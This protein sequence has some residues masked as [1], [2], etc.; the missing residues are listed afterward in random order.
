MQARR[1]R[2]VESVSAAQWDACFP[3]DYPFTRHAFLSALERSGSVGGD[4]GWGPSHLAIEQDDVVVGAAPVY[5]KAHSYGEFV[6]D[7]AWAQVCRKLRIRY[8]PKA[9]LAVPFTP[10]AG[11]RLG[12]KS[13]AA[14]T[15]LVAA[16]QTLTEAQGLSSAHALFLTGEEAEV[17]AAAGFMA[18][19]DIQFHWHNPGYADFAGFLAQLSHDKRK[20]ILRERRRIQEAGLRFERECGEA[21][22]ESAWMEVYALYANTYHERGQAP[23]L[24]PEFF[25]DYGRAPGNPIR[26][27][28]A[29]DGSRRVAVAMTWVGGTT[30]YGRHWGAA[31]RYHSLHFE[32]CYYQGIEW[33]IQTGLQR[34]D[35]GAQ[36]EHKLA[37]GFAPQS[38][39]SAHW[40]AQPELHEAFAEAMLRECEA[41]D[42]HGEWLAERSP[43]RQ[44]EDVRG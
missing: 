1:L 31:E 4:S 38:T 23:Y 40:L 6:F 5:L 32:T 26:L 22:S 33:C 18:R 36:G 11:A 7:F 2:S 17:F 15:A 3:A 34:F 24:T 10:V 20:K 39:Q 14:R 12:A 35:A 25:L 29:F 43:Y 41:V 21:L 8:Y 37:R 9:L 28:S 19:H 27:I 30:L 13:G 44:G 42:S 16:L